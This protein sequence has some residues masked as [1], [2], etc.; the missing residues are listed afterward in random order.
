MPTYLPKLVKNSPNQATCCIQLLLLS[1]GT[2]H[3]PINFELTGLV[4]QAT[5]VAL[6][7]AVDVVVVDRKEALSANS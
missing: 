5:A 6:Q 7:L 2:H 1:Q 3:F 4:S